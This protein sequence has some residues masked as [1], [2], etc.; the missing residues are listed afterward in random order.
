ML[1]WSATG[2]GNRGGLGPL[3]PP[4]RA[5]YTEG[6]MCAWSKEAMAAAV[7]CE[8]FYQGHVQGVGFRY[9]TRAIASSFAITGFVRNLPDGRVHVLVEGAKQETSRFLSEVAE[10][11]GHYIHHVETSYS[12]ATGEFSA[13]SIAF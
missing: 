11:M 10:R 2:V 9:S 3:Q 7:R 5:G 4:G 6:S 13:F 12:E 1:A 8:A